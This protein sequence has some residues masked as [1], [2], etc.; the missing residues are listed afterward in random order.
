MVREGVRAEAALVSRQV[1]EVRGLGN[2]TIRRLDRIESDYAA[3]RNARV[4]DL[5]V[6]VELISSSWNAVEER[7]SRIEQSLAQPPAP[8][9]YSVEQRR[10]AS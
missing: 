2:Q 6:V 5:A 7:L 10:A 1:A 3:E 8:E 4:D 9:L